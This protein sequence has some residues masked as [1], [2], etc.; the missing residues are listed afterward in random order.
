M[1]FI[2]KDLLLILWLNQFNP[3][4]EN[5]FLFVMMNALLNVVTFIVLLTGDWFCPKFPFTSLLVL[6]LHT[7]DRLA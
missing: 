5:M 6:L 2:L 4:E 3:W 7:N 1:L